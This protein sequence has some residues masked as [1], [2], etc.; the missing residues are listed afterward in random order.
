MW[1]QSRVAVRK[2]GAQS[3][4]PDPRNRA[5]EALSFFDFGAPGPAD[6]FIRAA[7]SGSG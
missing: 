1:S 3:F 5:I 6:V 2:A 7:A 4:T